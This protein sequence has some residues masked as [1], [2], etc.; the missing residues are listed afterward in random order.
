MENHLGWGLPIRNPI[1]PNERGEPDWKEPFGQAVR[2]QSVDNG[3][4]RWRSPGKGWS[5]G[6]P[7]A[8]VTEPPL[9]ES[10]P[11]A[12]HLQTS[13]EASGVTDLNLGEMSDLL[14]T[15]A[16][17]CQ[18]P[19]VRTLSP[20]SRCQWSLGK[21]GKKGG[22]LGCDPVSRHLREDAEHLT[23]KSVTR[24]ACQGGVGALSAGLCSWRR[25]RGRA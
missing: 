19:A 16:Q 21:V 14:G 15:R 20:S 24:A 7:V 22:R 13:G 12:R 17:H 6:E 4:R 25:G 8:E 2:I 11:C 3:G 1:K 10:R 18:T 5:Q 23:F 9:T